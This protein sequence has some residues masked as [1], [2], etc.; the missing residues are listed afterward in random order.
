MHKLRMAIHLIL[1]TSSSNREIGRQTGLAYNTIR[2]YRYVTEENKLQLDQLQQME[3]AKLQAMFNRRGS[4]SAEKRLPDWAYIHRELQ[5][6]G[7]T[8][9][10]LWMEYREE[11]PESAYELSRFNDLYREWAGK[12]ALSMRQQYEPGERGWTDFS[13]KRM[14]WVDP[15]TGE[16]HNVEI[17]VATAGVSGLL[18]AYAVPSQRQEHWVEAHCAWYDFL[19]G[20]PKITVPDNLKSAV[21]KA[22]RDPVLNPAYR[23]MAD[24]YGTLILPA[25]ARRPKDKATV[26]GGVLIFQR[27]GIARLRN[28]VFH[29]L[30][31]LNAAIRECVDIINARIMRRYKQSRR[32]RF[33]TI[34]KPALL[35]LPNRYEYG[36]WIGPLRVPPDYHVAVKNHFYSVPYRLVQQEVYAR[37]TPVTV[38]IFSTRERVASHARSEA[39]GAK[40]TDRAHMPEQHLAWADHSPERYLQW[41]QGLA[42]EVFSVVDRVLGD[43]RHPAGAL[44]AC[45]HLQKL[46]RTYGKERFVRACGKALEIKSPTVK[47]IRS[48]LQHGLEDRTQERSPRRNLPHHRNVRG[49][50]YYQGE[51]VCHAD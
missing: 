38:E 47:S 5:R 16:C 19:D 29:C 26:E 25:R 7:V 15:S 9:M 33:E 30:A 22:G 34:D 44:N 32:Q 8:R 6:K 31:E 23:E 42:S 4:L 50:S 20:V 1:S 51:D 3:D 24:H 37:C 11:E 35:P 17:F 18:F 2:R 39:I 45:A 27:W 12:H 36:E 40:S 21:Q 14:H 13:G 46:S 48:I 43:A 49:A 10:L 41:A 28:R